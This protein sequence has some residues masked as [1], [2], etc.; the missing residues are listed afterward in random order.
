MNSESWVEGYKLPFLDHAATREVDAVECA[1][2]FSRFAKVMQYEPVMQNEVFCHR[3]S[4]VHGVQMS[5]VSLAHP[6]MNIEYTEND[7]LKH[8]FAL[9]LL[10]LNRSFVD[11]NSLVAGPGQGLSKPIGPGV[12]LA[13]S[14]YAGIAIF[15]S[16]ELIV[17][18]VLAL[19]P[20]G[21]SLKKLTAS[22]GRPTLFRSEDN[23]EKILIS[24]LRRLISLIDAMVEP[25]STRLACVSIED[26]IVTRIAALLL[27]QLIKQ[28][29]RSTNNLDAD[30]RQLRFDGLIDYIPANLNKDLSLADL[31]IHSGLSSTGLMQMFW[32]H[33]SC[34]PMQWIRNER[35]KRLDQQFG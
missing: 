25:N 32:H 15:F 29:G 10:G 5:I 14:N 27:P 34:S 22:L 33:F 9:P 28:D 4:V 1:K 23:H 11:E 13:T 35:I 6:A 21:S 3:S 26:K 16:H 7:S 18:S 31:C 12:R 2:K 8:C 30:A 20:S 19:E 17:K 24:Q